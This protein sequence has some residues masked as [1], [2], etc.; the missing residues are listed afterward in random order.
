MTLPSG[1]SRRE[2]FLKIGILFNTLVGAALAVPIVRYIFSP[3]TR[4]RRLGYESW[5][6]LG[7]VDQF[8]SGQTRP[9]THRDPAGCPARLARWELID[10]AARSAETTSALPSHLNFRFR[11]LP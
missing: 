11:P 4:G 9:A 5:L 6:S 8:P 3:I 2:L 1:L 7:S 10:R